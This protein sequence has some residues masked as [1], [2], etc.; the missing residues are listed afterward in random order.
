MS[1][2]AKENHT[3]LD[4]L[5]G[6]GEPNR[7]LDRLGL[8]AM[9]YYASVRTKKKPTCPGRPSTESPAGSLGSLGPKAPM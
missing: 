6:G 8:Y 7:K 4:G 2:L 3:E 1:K 5:V 9:L